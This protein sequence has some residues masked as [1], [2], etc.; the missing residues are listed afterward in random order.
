MAFKGISAGIACLIVLAVFT[1]WLLFR[2]PDTHSHTTSQ[3]IAINKLLYKLRK[4]CIIGQIDVAQN[5]VE[6]VKQEWGYL[7]VILRGQTVYPADSLQTLDSLVRS[8]RNKDDSKRLL[9]IVLMEINAVNNRLDKV[10]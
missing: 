8:M 1:A 5:T 10:H 4:E 9:P 2:Q 7:D 3:V 6:D